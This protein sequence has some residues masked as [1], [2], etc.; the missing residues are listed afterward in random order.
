MK[1]RSFCRKAAKDSIY[2][3]IKSA[4]LNVENECSRWIPGLQR[5]FLH[6]QL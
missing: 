3:V 4:G 2:I 5:H 1:L 6:L